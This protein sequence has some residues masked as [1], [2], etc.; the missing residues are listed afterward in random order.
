M[1]QIDYTGLAAEIANIGAN[2]QRATAELQAAT[3]TAATVD[4]LKAE[5]AT[6]QDDLTASQAA[7]ADLTAQIKADD[8]ALVAAL[9]PAAGAAP[10]AA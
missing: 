4:Q 2:V 6:L 3:A 9:A 7:V 1:S 8:D 5:N 10:A